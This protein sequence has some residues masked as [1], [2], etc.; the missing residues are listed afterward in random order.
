MESNTPKFSNNII[1]DEIKYS[2]SITNI[3]FNQF[4]T[5]LLAVGDQLGRISIFDLRTQKPA[6]L[7]QNKNHR[8]DIKYKYIFYL[9]PYEVC[10]RRKYVILFSR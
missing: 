9:Y 3:E 2:S 8:I 5:N 10:C 4:Q 7:I 6:K 1:K